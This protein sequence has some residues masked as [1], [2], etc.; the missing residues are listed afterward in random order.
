[1]KLIMWHSLLNMNVIYFRADN[2]NFGESK[3]E[4]G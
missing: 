4:K 3:Y 1:M 2:E